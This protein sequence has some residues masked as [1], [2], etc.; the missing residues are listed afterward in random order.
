MKI[1]VI[2]VNYDYKNIMYRQFYNYLSYNNEVDY[3]GPGYVSRETLESGLLQFIDKKEYDA[4]ILGVYF[5]YSACTGEGRYNAYY[6]HRTVIPY[7]NVNDAYQCC[8]KIYEQLKSI[9]GIVKI[10]FY[11]EDDMFMPM[12]DYEICDE[13]VQRGFF[14]M[15]PPS[16]TMHKYSKEMLEQ[17]PLLSNLMINFVEQNMERYIPLTLHAISY[18]EIFY[19]CYSSREYDWCVPGNRSTKYYPMR[20]VIYNK[21]KN[22]SCKFWNDDPY[23]KLSVATI[24]RENI[25][26]YVFRNREEKMI[27]RFLG[28]NIYISS[29]PKMDYIAACREKYLESMRRTKAVFVEG[30]IG[31]VL[32]RKYY[33]ACA[34]GALMIGLEVPGM[35]AMGFLDGY[36]CRIVNEADI[37]KRIEEIMRDECNN[38]KIAANGQKLILEKHMFTNR[39]LS[40]S[41][42]IEKIKSGNYRGA[43]WDKGDYILRND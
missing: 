38:E 33:E 23:Q 13:L 41:Q 36:N 10:F 16:Q 8:R 34:C 14:L 30:S 1:L 17:N 37:D 28:K 7:Y 27:S 35:E 22:K 40:L 39:A 29:H 4:L 12:K 11:R 31:K 18:H 25:N 21:L 43:Y 15:G 6:I 2:D 3:F 5:V 19:T 24:E 9:I 26:W 20:E 32:V 42:T